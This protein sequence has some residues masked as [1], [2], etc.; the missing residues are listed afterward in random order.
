MWTT[1]TRHSGLAVTR[2]SVP[3]RYLE[4][5][6]AFPLRRLR[7]K[8]EHEQAL[9]VLRSLNGKN[10]QSTNDYARVL[11]DQVLEFEKRMG[12]GDELRKTRLTPA[13]RIEIRMQDM[14]IP[15][16]S[17]LARAI[18]VQQSNL[19]EMMSGKRGF[20]KNAIAG[21]YRVLKIRPEVFLKTK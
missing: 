16:V 18:G 14:G 1:I 4:L 2:P 11:I 21:L 9:K 15:S 17:A 13:E 20:S 6:Q 8:R 10:G 19:S 12:Y 5:V 3:D 7:S